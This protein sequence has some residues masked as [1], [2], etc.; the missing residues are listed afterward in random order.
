M[1]REEE[2]TFQFS[3]CS[4][5]KPGESNFWVK[6]CLVQERTLFD[7]VAMLLLLQVNSKKQPA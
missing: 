6:I 2:S 7:F 3:W 5:W 4:I 1:P